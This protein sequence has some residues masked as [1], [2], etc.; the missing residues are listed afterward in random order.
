[1]KIDINTKYIFYLLIHTHTTPNNTPMFRFISLLHMRN[2]SSAAKSKSNCAS[3]NTRCK[4]TNGNAP[5]TACNCVPKCQ[6]METRDELDAFIANVNCRVKC[7]H[8]NADPK[9]GDC[10]CA[11]VCIADMSELYCIM[12]SNRP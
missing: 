2:Y 3:S 6:I 5:L 11:N 9:P 10:S 7:A 4:M 12:A 1:M 8:T